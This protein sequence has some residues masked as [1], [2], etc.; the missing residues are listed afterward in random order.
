VPEIVM[1]GLRPDAPIFVPVLV[2]D[3][4]DVVLRKDSM[5]RLARWQRQGFGDGV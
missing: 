2:P 3:E 1:G 5:S 4:E